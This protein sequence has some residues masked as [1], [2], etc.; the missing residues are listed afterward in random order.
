[1]PQTQYNVQSLLLLPHDVEMDNVLY[2][3]STLP[4]LNIPS[5]FR[6]DTRLAWKVVDNVELSLVGQ[7]LLQAQ[8]KEFS[9]FLY[10]P[11]VEIPRAVYANVRWNF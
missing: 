2:Y 1:S 3:V 7:N 5:Y 4:S 8:H 6:F 10:Q 11:T 9:G